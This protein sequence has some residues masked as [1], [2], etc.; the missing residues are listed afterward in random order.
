VEANLLPGVKID[1]FAFTDTIEGYTEFSLSDIDIPEEGIFAGIKGSSG[2]NALLD[3][4]GQG[5]HT[6]INS[7]GSWELATSGELLMDGI[8]SHVP[9]PSMRGP[10]DILSFDVLKST[11]PSIWTKIAS[12]LTGNLYTDTLIQENREYFYKIMV[13]FGNPV[14]SFFSS[15][16]GMF[17]D[18]SPPELDTVII[19]ELDEDRLLLSAALRDTSGIAWDSLGYKNGDTINVISEDSCKNNEYFF[20]ITFSGDTLAYFLKAKDL[21]LIGN[22]ARYPESGFY[23]W[24]TLAGL[25]EELIPDSTYLIRMLNVL[26]SRNIEIRYALSEESNVKIMFFDILGR[27]A[28]TLVDKTQKAGYYSVPLKSSTLPHGI[29]FLRMEAGGYQKTLKLVK[30]K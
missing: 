17:I 14:D 27:K 20:S 1:S 15:S 2:L 6:A 8:V 13:S 26:V 4:Y 24:G 12:G 30:V 3:G 9:P 28:E 7:G 19:D 16:R 10:S 22:Y 5:S 25:P 21:S 11:E 29:Y 18:F 23:K